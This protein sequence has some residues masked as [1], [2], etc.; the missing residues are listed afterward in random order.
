MNDQQFYEAIGYL[1]GRNVLIEAEVAKGRP[2][3]KF[4]REYLDITGELVAT[5]DEY[6][7]IDNK[8]G[9]ELRLYLSD[10]TNAPSQLNV[11]L[12]SDNYRG[13]SARINN[14]ELVMKMFRHG[15]R[16]GPNQDPI[17]I[18]STVPEFHISDFERGASL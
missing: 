18:R 1:S 7:R 4:E 5:L 16:V 13:Y 17:L 15:F 10:V 9:A 3:T 6:H 11:L 2:S 8:Y 12:R 14:N